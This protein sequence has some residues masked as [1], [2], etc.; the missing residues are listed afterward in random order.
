[1]MHLL[2]VGDGDRDSASVPP[3]VEKMLNVAVRSV[4]RPW[5]R[6]HS[7]KGGKGYA[8]RLLFAVKQAHDLKVDGLVA[9]VD[10]DRSPNRKKLRELQDARADQRQ[11]APPFPTALGEANPH[12]EAWLLDDPVAVAKVLKLAA[13]RI[14]NI[15]NVQYP[16][17]TLND[18]WQTSERADVLIL[19]I[20]T[21]IAQQLDI[22]RCQHKKETGLHH[23]LEDVRQEL[24]SLVKS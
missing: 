7:A 5:A 24:A 20:L 6:L 12:G 21:E 8:R 4:F 22:Q 11:S 16:K 2:I 23:F 17:D 9:T 15:R 14:P 3:L 13:D 10:T 1:M 18:L 19:T